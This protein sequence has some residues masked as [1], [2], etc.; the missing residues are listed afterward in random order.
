MSAT[1]TLHGRRVRAALVRDRE[2]AGAVIRAAS[3]LQ[4]LDAEL[5]GAQQHAVPRPPSRGQ[6]VTPTT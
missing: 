6:L 4:Q 2:P 5:R 1:S 3:A